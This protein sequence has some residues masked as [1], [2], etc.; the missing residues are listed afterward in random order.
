M[1]HYLSAFACKTMICSWRVLNG[2]LDKFSGGVSVTF[3]WPASTRACC[4]ALCKKK[5]G[6]EELGLPDPRDCMLTLVMNMQALQPVVSRIQQSCGVKMLSARCLAPHVAALALQAPKATHAHPSVV[7]VENLEP[8]MF[9]VANKLEWPAGNSP[10]MPHSY[11][12][13]LLLQPGR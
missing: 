8:P 5:G 1:F 3:F 2:Q 10:C 13:H 7:K 6:R 11:T 9:H 12:A 4:Q